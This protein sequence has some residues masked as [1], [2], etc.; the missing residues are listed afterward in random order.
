MQ[1]KKYEIEKIKKVSSLNKRK[2][3]TLSPQP[4]DVFQKNKKNNQ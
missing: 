3:A 2:T 4:K 1:L